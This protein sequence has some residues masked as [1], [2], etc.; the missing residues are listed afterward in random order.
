MRIEQW[1]PADEKTARACYDVTLAAH[2]VDEPVEPPL[3]FGA[4]GIFLRDGWDCDP[5]ELWVA[6][7]DGGTAVGYYRINLPDLENLDGAYGELVVHPAARRRGIGRELLRHAGGRAAVHGR[8]RFAA[9]TTAGADGD[10]FAQ[11]VGAR[12][13]LEE[14]RRIQYL[15]EIAP[16]TVDA[17]R[18]TA[19][20][21]AAGYSV[22]SWEGPVPDRYLA[23]MAGVLNAFNDAPRGANEQPAIWDADRVRERTG[24]LVRAGVVRAYSVAASCDASGEMA[25]FT[26]VAIDPESPTWGFQWLTAVVR[27]HRGHRLGLLVKTEML[28]LLAT[29]EPQVDRV[30]TGNAAANEHMIAINEQLGYKVVEPGWRFYEMP[31]ADML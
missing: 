9:T 3:S 7:G 21:A 18:A 25:A 6:S 30:A 20:Q 28:S 16:G 1:D 27:A 29:A 19:S 13:D 23:S 8:T 31:V 15:R 24:S 11:A 2:R 22:T 10:A 26:Q 17:L 12:L 14:I 5:G 4:F